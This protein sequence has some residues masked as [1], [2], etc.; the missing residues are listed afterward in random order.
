MASPASAA[1][2]AAASAASSVSLSAAAPATTAAI[3]CP[4][5][6]TAVEPLPRLGS[7]ARASLAASLSAAGPLVATV[8][9]LVV[10]AS[11]A[12]RAFTGRACR[13]RVFRYPLPLGLAAPAAFL[14]C[15]RTVCKQVV[16]ALLEN[17]NH[18]LLENYNHAL[19]ENY[20]HAL[21]ENYNHALLENYN[22]ALLEN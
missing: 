3:A 1:P 2:A 20:N 19:L 17:Y 22:H 11:V 5:V 8:Y 12:P 9:S 14:H 15:D 4:P 18:A 10:A 16:Y 7:S 13:N 21:L 6:D